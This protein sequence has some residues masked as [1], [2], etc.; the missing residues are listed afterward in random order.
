MISTVLSWLCNRGQVDFLVSTV[1]VLV[2]RDTRPTGTM[3]RYHH[4]LLPAP[5][6]NPPSATSPRQASPASR[7]RWAGQAGR[8]DP[9]SQ[10]LCRAMMIVCGIIIAIKMP[11][12]RWPPRAGAPPVT[13][14]IHLRPSSAPPPFLL[15]H[16]VQARTFTRAPV[17]IRPLSS[18]IAA[19]G[20][21]AARGSAQPEGTAVPRDPAYSLLREWWGMG[22]PFRRVLAP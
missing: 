16:H 15:L 4:H 9:D 12:W 13:F 19:M 2:N 18:A 7:S 5:F 20:A 21:A 17:Q 10:S 8:A 1:V 3:E 6:L 22:R 14:S 11:S